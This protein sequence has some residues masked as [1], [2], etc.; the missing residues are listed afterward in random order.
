MKS[1]I[2]KDLLFTHFMGKTSAMQKQMIDE[3]AK[4]LAHEELY[5]TWL[6]EYEAMYPEYEANVDK[7]IDEYYFFLK[8][9]K[10]VSNNP[11]VE[12]TTKVRTMGRSTWLR[13]SMAASVILCLFLTAWLT[14]N[15]WKYQTFQTAFGQTRTLHLEDGSQVTLNS[16]SSLK[17]PR[18]GFGQTTR[19]VFLEGEASFSIKHTPTHQ[20]FMVGTSNQFEV[21]VL[22]TEFTVFTRER[23]SKVVLNK[24]KV[25]LHLHYGSQTRTMA[26]SP[27][28]LITMDNQNRIQKTV[29]PQPELHAAWMGHRY[30]FKQTT[31]REINYLL[32]EN[33]GISAE[34]DKKELLDQTLSGTFTADN[35]DEFLN[36]L[37]T[38]L[39][40]H[41]TRQE[42]KVFIS[43]DNL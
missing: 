17:V 4:E 31:L 13:W 28:D 8:K 20:K 21:E 3:W 18:W 11:E 32:Y 7:A 24:G 40:L 5:Y 36:L 16:N 27:G 2:T 37:E 33:Y 34:V 22:G 26:M 1:A 29:T 19:Q 12:S 43:Q 38:V 41:I 14:R 23:G 9:I 10:A 6:E 15:T 42:N 30:I 39:D 25:Q 35:V